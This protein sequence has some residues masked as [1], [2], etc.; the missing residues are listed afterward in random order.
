MKKELQSLKE[1]LLKTKKIKDYKYSKQLNHEP[2]SKEEITGTLQQL[3]TID[4]KLSEI[5]KT[6]GNFYFESDREHIDFIIEVS[7]DFMYINPLHMFESLGAVQIQSELINFMKDLFFCDGVGSTTSGG[8]E[9]IFIA[10][11]TLR[12]KAKELGITRPKIIASQTA[13]AAIDKACGYLEIEHVIVPHCQITGTANLKKMAQEIDDRTIGVYLSGINFPHGNV[14]DVKWMNDYLLGKD[15]KSGDVD[16]KAQ[17]KYEHVGIF[18]DGCLGGFFTSVSAHLN[19]GRFPVIDFRL[20]KVWMMSCDPHKYAM[21]PKG[22]SV[23]LFKNEA[24]KVHSIFKAPYWPGGIYATPGLMGSTTTTPIVGAWAS[25]KR[26]GMSGIIEN[27]KMITKSIDELS[28]G[29]RRIPELRLI[30]DP[31]GCSVAFSFSEKMSSKFNVI[32]LNDILKKKSNWHLSIS[33]YPLAIRISITRNNHRN[34]NES[35]IAD[36]KKAIKEYQDNYS[37]HH[38]E[39]LDSMVFYG[40]VLDMPTSISEKI[41]SYVLVYINTLD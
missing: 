29:I 7:K 25:L 15:P 14:D 1:N 20:E 32:I 22:C 17:A 8:T 6:S 21:S 9:S 2:F 12:E 11:Y 10:V 27:Y 41:L 33:N 30:G 5:G 40:S 28:A 19:D 23:L 31:K 35:L 38:N 37:E 26:M 39:K 13:H 16:R 34:I 18:V 24:L 36:L 4:Y 3:K